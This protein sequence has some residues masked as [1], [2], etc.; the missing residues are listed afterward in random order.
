MNLRITYL[1]SF[2]AFILI[3]SNNVEAKRKRPYNRVGAPASSN[4]GIGVGNAF[5]VGDQRLY[6]ISNYKQQSEIQPS[7][8]FFYNQNL[9]R[10]CNFTLRYQNANMFTMHQSKQYAFNINLQNF[11]A[12]YEYSLNN[13]ADYAQG[14]FAVNSVFGLGMLN[15][16]AK[17]YGINE[18]ESEDI[19]SSIGY[20][21]NNKVESATKT[22]QSSPETKYAFNATVGLNLGYKIANPIII[23]WQN[24]LNI[25]SIST[26]TGNINR[27]TTLPP[28]SYFYTG[29]GLLVKIGTAS[30]RSCPRF[31]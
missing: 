25:T 21:Q 7:F 23:V 2:A 30:G 27:N 26:L 18:N 15:Y 3:F 9:S 13:N 5:Y 17:F 24:S 4:I 31:Y 8:T 10:R 28:D 12:I 22:A 19:Y 29:I 11:S 14:R 20:G 1:F 16:K 6:A